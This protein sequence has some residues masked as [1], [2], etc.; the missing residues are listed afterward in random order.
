V[1][2]PASASAAEPDV[3]PSVVYLLARFPEPYQT[4]VRDEIWNLRARGAR[5]SVLAL[6]SGAGAD[7]AWAGPYRVLPRPGP[8]RS[9][10][11][12]LWFAAHRP[13]RY[14]A[15]LARIARAGE[16]WKFAA[17]ALVTEARRMVASAA[18]DH[19]HTH[20][21]WSAA[22]VAG[23][24]AA[25]LGTPASITVHA[26]DLYATSP[27]RLRARLHAFDR[28]VTVVDFNVDFLERRKV[29]RQGDPRIVVVACGVDVPERLADPAAVDLDVVAVGRLI[30]KKGFDVLLRALADLRTDRPGLTAVVVGDGPER[31]RL[32]ALA[33]ELDLTGTVRFRG[34]LPRGLALAEIDRARVFCLPARATGDGDMDAMPVVLREAMARGVPVVTT[35]I[36]GIPESVD[37]SVGWLVAPGDQA[38]LVAALAESLDDESGRLLRGAAA[39]SRAA[40]RWRAEDQAA[41]LAR[42][43]WGPRG[44]T[45]VDGQAH[46]LK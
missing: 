3:R 27:R 34:A 32:E 4:F 9:V 18:P 13:R 28:I 7:P 10:A 44:T 11:D 33:A 39:R 5:V 17:G 8:R 38:A 2:P 15:F 19:C 46:G 45:P 26:K 36:A 1:A 43:F 16:G 6:S 21:A 29:V 20:F 37:A 14:L 30:E 31:P 24:L 22:P 41:T 25:L 35:A 42:L 12:H 40:Q 23:Y